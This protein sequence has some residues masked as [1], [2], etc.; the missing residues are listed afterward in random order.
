[1]CPDHYS[2]KVGK[3][4]GSPKN[5]KRHLYLGLNVVNIQ[6]FLHLLIWR[7]VGNRS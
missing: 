3:M 1:M 2:N 6:I 7:C 4:C 5:I